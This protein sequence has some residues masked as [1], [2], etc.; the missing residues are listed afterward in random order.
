MKEAVQHLGKWNHRAA[1]AVTPAVFAWAEATARVPVLRTFKHRESPVPD[2]FSAVTT[3]ESR[4]ISPW[5]ATREQKT[6][7]QMGPAD[8]LSGAPCEET[9]IEKGELD[10]SVAS[11][12]AKSFVSE[13]KFSAH[14][15]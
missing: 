1:T 6:R 2:T 13:L 11:S 15:N 7:E 3:V 5:Y 10:C 14:W 9:D 12:H 8:T 4:D